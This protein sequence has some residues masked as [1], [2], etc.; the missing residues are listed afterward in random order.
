MYKASKKEKDI[1]EQKV[2]TEQWSERLMIKDEDQEEE[3]KKSI[4][5]EMMGQKQVLGHVVESA[6]LHLT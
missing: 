3:E 5:R 4:G 2:V 6:P 1:F